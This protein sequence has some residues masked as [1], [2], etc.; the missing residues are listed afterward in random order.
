M[1]KV[2]LRGVCCP[3]N[4]VKAMLVIEELDIGDVAEFLLD[5]GEPIENVPR[6]VE[7]AGHRILALENV[8]DYFRLTVEKG[9]EAD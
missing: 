4:F 5:G 3:M 6:S 9:E 8:E 7:Q 2:D 1:Q